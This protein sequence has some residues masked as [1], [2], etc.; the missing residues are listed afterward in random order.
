[1]PAIGNADCVIHNPH[2][3]QQLTKLSIG[4]QEREDDPLSD[5]NPLRSAI[6]DDYRPYA[7]C[8][9][10]ALCANNQRP[11]DNHRLSATWS[12]QVNL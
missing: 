11:T 9:L 4:A 5:G 1:M 12:V 10:S 6:T 7:L 2:I 8:I 3:I